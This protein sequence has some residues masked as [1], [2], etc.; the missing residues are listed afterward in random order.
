M[1]N[2][3]LVGVFD[4]T[5]HAF[6][7]MFLR[8]SESFDVM[9]YSC[10]HHLVKPLSVSFFI[11]VPTEVVLNTR[12]PFESVINGTIMK[13]QL[14]VMATPNHETAN[15]FNLLLI[16]VMMVFAQLVQV[17][18]VKLGGSCF[19]WF[20]YAMYLSTHVLQSV[21]GEET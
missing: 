1:I 21:F 3:P 14:E 15:P 8:L 17:G 13:E 4:A 19:E 5:L 18:I 12:L 7:Y 6:G 16:M 20:E 11:S 9:L 10:T 2:V